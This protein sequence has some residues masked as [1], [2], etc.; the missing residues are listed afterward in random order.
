MLGI[1]QLKR[2]YGSPHRLKYKTVIPTELVASDLQA[3]ESIH[4][5]YSGYGTEI[6]V[7][8][9]TPM[10]KPLVSALLSPLQNLYKAALA[11]V[12]KTGPTGLPSSLPSLKGDALLWTPRLHNPTIHCDGVGAR[13]GISSC[14]HNSNTGCLSLWVQAIS[15]CLFLVLPNFI[16]Q[17][18]TFTQKHN[19]LLSQAG[20]PSWEV[21]TVLGTERHREKQTC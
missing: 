17:E 19:L 2:S 4:Y 5:I 1:F 21:T 8:L 11:I 14:S 6:H 9:W 15:G 10:T 16:R 3:S 18:A 12:M 20:N 7:Y 13:H